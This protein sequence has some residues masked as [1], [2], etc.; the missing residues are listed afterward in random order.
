MTMHGNMD[1]LEWIF[2]GVFLAGFVVLYLVIAVIVWL[3][4][5][6]TRTA[7]RWPLVLLGMLVWRQ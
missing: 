2:G 7:L 4:W 1:W 5:R 3:F 6:D